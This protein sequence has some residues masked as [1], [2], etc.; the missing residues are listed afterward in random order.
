MAQDAESVGCDFPAVAIVIPGAQELVSGEVDRLRRGHF[1]GAD[2]EDIAVTR[3][4]IG[5]LVVLFGV[6]FGVAEIEHLH[7]DSMGKTPFSGGQLVNGLGCGPDEET[8]VPA[9]FL[10]HPFTGEFEVFQRFAIANHAGWFAGAEGVSTF[11]NP[12]VVVA[13]DVDEVF[14]FEHLPTCGTG[15]TWSCIFD[16]RRRLGSEGVKSRPCRRCRCLPRR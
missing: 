3:E 4:P 15:V 8:G 14:D 10:V 1:D 12:G 5:R 11:P 2:R 13:V 7:F 9:L 16:D 6:D